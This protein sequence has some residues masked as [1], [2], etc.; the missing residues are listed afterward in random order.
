MLLAA[1]ASATCVLC[2]TPA[3]LRVRDLELAGALTAGG[4]A[5]SGQAPAGR[6]CRAV[7]EGR[8]STGRAPV[9]AGGCEGAGR[10]ALVASVLG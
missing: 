9:S 1:S 10:R 7:A 5:D 6:T 8:P 3:W 2:T 4:T